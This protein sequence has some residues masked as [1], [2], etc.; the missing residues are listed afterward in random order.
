M[1][2]EKA[3][4][5]IIRGVDYSETSRIFTFYT[6]QYGRMSALAKGAK[7][8]SSKLVGHTDLFSHGQIVFASGRSRD[9]LHILTE[10]CAFDVFPQIRQELP[11]YYAACHAAA[12]VHA[13]TA[14]EDP[15]P[16]LFDELLALLRRLD[17]GVE[18]ALALF[19]FE[20]RLLVLTG[21]MPEVSRC[22][23]CGKQMREKRV[24]FSPGLGGIVC[25]QCA[26]GEADLVTNVQSGALS[27]LAR[28]ARGKLT[29]LHRVTV[30]SFVVREVRAFLDGFEAHIL[31]KA[32]RTAKHLH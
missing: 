18:P 2:Y 15:S 16:E 30:A 13:M 3:D 7:R 6:R 29:K 8:K 32:L 20:A 27:L 17:A 9:R 10:S 31:G 12:L 11:R 5:I 23:A 26:A 28:L 1:P 24:A 22:A 25:K 19:A 14:E 4:A 21:F